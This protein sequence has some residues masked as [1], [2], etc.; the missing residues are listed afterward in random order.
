MGNYPP[1]YCPYC[2]SE[3]SDAN[4]P[5]AYYCESCGDYVF[6]NPTPAARVAVLDGDRILLVKVESR[7]LWGTP[8]G[9]VEAGEDPDEAGA[10]EL[11]EET[12]LTVDPDDLVLF[13]A[14][15]FSK[16]DRMPKTS[17]SYAV[18][19]S[20]VGGSP[21]PG[22]EPG[23]VEFRSPAELAA[24]EGRLLTSWPDAHRDL[25]WWLREGRAALSASQR[26]ATGSDTDS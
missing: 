5:T 15:T 13:D 2:G 3:L 21:R 24:G 22:E 17:I 6:H 14:R 7:D 11:R 18:D 9:M 4:P 12:G 10:R 20:K 19:R 16:F 1:D 23:A 8:G 25:E 26:D